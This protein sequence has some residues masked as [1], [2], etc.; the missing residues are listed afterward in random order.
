MLPNR[1]GFRDGAAQIASCQASPLFQGEIGKGA[2]Q[3]LDQVAAVKPFTKYAGRARSAAEIPAVLKAAVQAAVSGRP[4]AA[5][6]D[7]PSDVLMASS[8]SSGVSCLQS[9][10]VI[11]ASPA[12][13]AAVLM[14]LVWLPGKI[15]QLRFVGQSIGLQSWPV[16]VRLLPCRCHPTRALQISA[17]A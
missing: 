9:Y 13:F 8:A 3:E 16:R 7:I 1:Q 11:W 14:L 6:V 5:Y 4:G 12:G 10:D 2:F 17:A 15:R